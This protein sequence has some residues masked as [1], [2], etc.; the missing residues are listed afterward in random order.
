MMLF[1][2]LGYSPD[3]SE[4]LGHS[5]LTPDAVRRKRY[6]EIQS[7]IKNCDSIELRT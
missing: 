7:K 3:L 1:N 5:E 2:W 6:N 4:N